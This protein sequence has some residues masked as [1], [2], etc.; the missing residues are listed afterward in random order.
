MYSYGYYSTY[1]VIFCRKISNQIWL[2]NIGKHTLGILCIHVQL[3]HTAAVV[4]N[5]LFIHGS[6]IWILSFFIAYVLI[7]YVSYILS[8]FIEHKAPFLLGKK[9]NIHCHNIY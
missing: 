6:F 2:V 1:R 5:K 8:V 7:V 9:D 3:C 4:L